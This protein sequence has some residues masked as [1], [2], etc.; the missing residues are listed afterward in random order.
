MRSRTVYIILRSISGMA[1]SLL[2]TAAAL[3]RI[4]IAK[5]EVYQL[6]LLGTA[7]EIAVFLFETPTGVLADMKS[8]KLSVIIGL[9]IIGFG[10]I[11]EGLT[12]YFWVIFL[13]QIIWGLG[14]TFISGALDSWVSDESGE[15][16]EQTFITAA[17][18][19]RGFSFFG[20]LLAAFIGTYDVRVAIYVAGAMF[21]IAGLFS[22]VYMK[23][24][25][26]HK[27]TH[28][29]SLL[30]SYYIHL[31]DGFKHMKGNGV[32]KVLFFVM[33]FYGLYSE[34][35]DRTYEL[36]ILDGL[37]FRS[38]ELA[39]IVIISIVNAFV[40]FIGVISLH[41]VKK[42]LKE[43]HHLVLWTINLTVMMIVGVLM[44]GLLPNQYIALFGYVIFMVT[45][46][47]TEPLLNSLIVKN[48]PSKIKAT[49]FSAFGQLDAIGQLLSG[50]LMVTLG[51]YFGI[52]GI[53]MVT[54]GLLLLPVLLLT[55]A[56]KHS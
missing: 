47:G 53:Y 23:E 1:F 7:L 30:R 29:E 46:E 52:E 12:I 11:L 43:S 17:Q 40:A 51:L 19:N 39:P 33:I 8:R 14:Y 35:I 20:I 36:H 13:S 38:L 50:A 3:Y 5:L 54:A 56:R 22:V 41:I 42:Y 48:T 32:L 21:L 28:D 9:F 25:N 24:D 15:P 4:D 2:F 26:F 49:V 55:K 27:V 34:G 16:V 6:I 18:F 37:G 31:T 10:F 45:R 44:F